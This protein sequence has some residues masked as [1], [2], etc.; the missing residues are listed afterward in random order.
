MSL[1]DFEV[2]LI[3]AMLGRGMRNKDIQFY[4]NTPQR[5]VNNGRI[6]EIKSGAR[7]PEIQPALEYEVDEFIENHPLT[8]ADR[9]LEE[10]RLPPQTGA[11]S[12]FTVLDNELVEVVADTHD[13]D[14]PS[15]DQLVLFEELVGKVEALWALGDNSLGAAKRPVENFRAIIQQQFNNIS[16]VLIWTR[17]NAL[18]A[19]IKAHDTVADNQDNPLGKLE[20]LCAE[21]LRDVVAIFNV[22]IANDPKGNQLDQTSLGPGERDSYAEA[23][24]E[25]AAVIQHAD[26]ITTDEA[27]SELNEQ[28]ENG[29]ANHPGIEG[30]QAL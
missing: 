18:R 20:P 7:W 3:K 14:N 25:I 10:P 4:F 1:S 8:L 2:G 5:P 13:S 27:Y 29:L 26:V 12:T 22:L 6:S 24:D 17:G 21:H 15:A 16:I 9:S 30:E 23:L 11:A 28:T 19:L